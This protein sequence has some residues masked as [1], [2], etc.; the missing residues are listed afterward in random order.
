MRIAII[1]RAPQASFSM[2]VYADGLVS[3]LKAVRPNWEIVE[4]TP[5]INLTPK[6]TTLYF[7]GWLVI[8]S[9]IGVIPSASSN[10]RQI[11]FTLSII[12]MDI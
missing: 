10:S 12:V 7:M 6:K 2:D 9:A 4:F 11:S 8:T 5:K 3:G 1:R